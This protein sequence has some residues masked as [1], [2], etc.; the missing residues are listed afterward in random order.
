MVKVLTN[1]LSNIL[2]KHDILKGP[3]FAG[4]PGG[5]TSQPIHIINNVIEDAHNRKKELWIILQDIAKAFDSVGMI[6]L[7][8]ALVFQTL[9][10]FWSSVCLRKGRWEYW[11][12]MGYLD[13]LQPRLSRLWYEEFSTTHCSVGYNKMH[14]WVMKW[15]SIGRV[16]TSFR[17]IHILGSRVQL[18]QTT[19]HGLLQTNTQPLKRSS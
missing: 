15:Q 19:L 3:N 17:M 16:T 1:R 4:L 2:I 14:L 5:S 8:Y 18:L 11:H 9:L 10:H 7:R 6:P 12:I 13:L